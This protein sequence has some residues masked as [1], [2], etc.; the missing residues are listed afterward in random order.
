MS[1]EFSDEFWS[2]I[3]AADMRNDKL[4]VALAY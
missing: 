1:A 4:I 2:I 3:D